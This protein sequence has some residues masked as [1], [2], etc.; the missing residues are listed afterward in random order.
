MLLFDLIELKFYFI[1][2]LHKKNKMS[3]LI[4]KQVQGDCEETLKSYIL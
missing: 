3:Q 2:A 1:P 4:L